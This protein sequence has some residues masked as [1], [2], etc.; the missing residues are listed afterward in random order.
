MS[1]VAILLDGGFV[2]KKLVALNSKTRRVSGDA[3]SPPEKFLLDPVFPTA[4]D[5][6][7]LV[8]RIMADDRVRGSELLR[9]YYYDGPPLAG[10]ELNPLS[11]KPYSFSG[12]YHSLNKRLQDSLAR[13]PDF[14]LR[15]GE[16]VF[17]GWS[18]R[19]DVLAEI[20][21]SP[22]P[23]TASD[24]APNV[25][26]KGVDLRIGLDVAMLSVKRT[27]DRIV[28]VTGDSDMIPAMKLARREGLWVYLD[29]MGHGVRSSMIEHADYVFNSSAPP[30]VANQPAG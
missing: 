3:G 8:R 6:V 4:A 24:L 19:T 20:A 21:T 29:T 1:R 5:V 14:A 10:S 30:A 15:K 25:E 9:A 16:T 2:K 26:Q 7:A 13:T 11:G 12:S 23:L 17:R 28:L 27:V 18:L 22:R